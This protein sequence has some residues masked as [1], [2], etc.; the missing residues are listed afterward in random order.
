[1]DQLAVVGPLAVSRGRTG[2]LD[3]RLAEP[4]VVVVLVVGEAG[5]DGERR[6]VGWLVGASLAYCAGAR[7]DVMPRDSASPSKKLRD[8]SLPS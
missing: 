7:L 1:V 5:V 2:R 8:P 4:V 6:P 3:G